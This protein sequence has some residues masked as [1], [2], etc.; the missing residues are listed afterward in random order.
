[1]CLCL[2]AGPLSFLEDITT[3]LQL[4][5][6]QNRNVTQESRKSKVL[7]CQMTGAE[8]IAVCSSHCINT[9]EEENPS[10]VCLQRHTTA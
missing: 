4:S 3:W 5:I 1:M 9:L 6:A 2:A 7:G 10:A 8:H